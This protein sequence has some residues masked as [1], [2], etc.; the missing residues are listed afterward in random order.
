MSRGTSFVLV[1]NRALTPIFFAMLSVTAALLLGDLYQIFFVAPVEA[2]MGIV[3][4]I[5][6]FHVS[7]AYAMYLG[8]AACFVGSVWYL[9][10]QSDLSD[11]IAHA[12]GE[13]AVA[14]GV[15]VMISGP[16]WARKA[17]GTYWLWDPRLTTTMLALL[18]YVAYLVLRA[19]GG[20]GEAERRFAAALGI[21]GVADLPVI[22]YSVRKWSGQHPEVITGNGGGVAKAMLPALF[23]SFTVFT[24]LAILLLWVRARGELIARRV[25][26]VHE[27]AIEFGI[28]TGEEQL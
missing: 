16:L 9:V 5:F 15:I 8:A 23:L 17:W 24:L 25:R 10:N 18:I 6:Y 7:S 2:T 3:Q 13:L 11:A 1:P 4:K 20:S 21:L 19:F 27:Q 12:G 14:F 28:L 26:Q 22:H